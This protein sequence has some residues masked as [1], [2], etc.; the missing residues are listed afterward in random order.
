MLFAR[1]LTNSLPGISPTTPISVDFAQVI[2][3]L[4]LQHLQPPNLSVIR[5]IGTGA[6]GEILSTFLDIFI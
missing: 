6:S 3:L 5:T 4:H 1:A 2:F